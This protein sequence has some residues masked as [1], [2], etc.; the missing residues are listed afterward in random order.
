MSAV[1]RSFVDSEVLDSLVV[2]VESSLELSGLTRLADRLL[3]LIFEVDVSDKLESLTLEGL[4]A[5][6]YLVGEPEHTFGV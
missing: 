2:A 4:A 6:I 1:L 3:Q 5:N